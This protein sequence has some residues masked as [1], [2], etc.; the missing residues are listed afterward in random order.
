MVSIFLTA[1]NG[2][3]TVSKRL[4]KKFRHSFSVATLPSQLPNSLC[5]RGSILT[6]PSQ[7]HRSSL[8]LPSQLP[9]SLWKWGHILM[10]RSQPPNA[11]LTDQQ[12][13]LLQNLDQ[14]R[15]TRTPAFWGYPLLPHDYPHYWVILK[16]LNFVINLTHDTPSNGSDYLWQIWK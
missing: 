1:P 16:F 7:L 4:A 11:S 12:D 2:E 13:I 5:K 15:T 6:L 9:N 14:S 8:T 10:F 3:L